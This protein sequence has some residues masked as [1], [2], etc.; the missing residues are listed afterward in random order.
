MICLVV[1][2]WG[3]F[4]VSCALDLCGCCGI[5]SWCGFG[6]VG[7]I[8]C[9]VGALWVCGFVFIVLPCVVFGFMFCCGGPVGLGCYF[10]LW[11]FV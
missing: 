7:L 1:V 8:L 5:D 4:R 11:R 9:L 10:G 6:C 2:V 3:G